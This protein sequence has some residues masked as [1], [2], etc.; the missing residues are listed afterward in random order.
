MTRL[1]VIGDIAED[2]TVY[3]ATPVAH[4]SDTHCRIVRHRGGSAANVAV[5]AAPLVP[6]HFIGCIGDD[7]AGDMLAAGLIGV[8]ARLQRTSAAPS[9]TIVVLVD[10]TGERDM[11][12]SRGAN[13]HLGPLDPS[14]L[15]GLTALH[16]TAYSLIGPGQTAAV[17]QDALRTVHAR[18]RLT[19]LDVSSRGLIEHFGTGRFLSLVDDL[20]PDVVFANA[21]EAALLSWDVDE[22]APR[23]VFVKHGAD[24]VLVRSPSGCWRIPVAPRVDA[25]DTT[26][27]GDA[28]AAGVLAH[29][30]ND[31][32]AAPETLV[33]AG[34]T[35]ALA[36]LRS[37][38]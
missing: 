4:A 5:A 37:R 14:W 31:A 23:L 7:P 6:T 17:V 20:A 12:P 3:A 13:S 30:L 11:F 27:A 34:H 1:G 33:Q 25:H 36:W 28:F 19:S 10:A 35:S 22:P 15:D 24:P 2:I 16:A 8:E 26:G 29:L 9:G 32:A 21:D 38:A 18:G